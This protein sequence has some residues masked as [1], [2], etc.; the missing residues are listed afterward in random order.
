MKLN[1]VINAAGARISGGDPYGW[2]CFGDNANF[3]EFRD[4]SGQGYAHAIYDT[5]NYT[6]YEINVTVPNRD[7]CFRW[8]NPEFKDAFYS[9]AESRGVDPEEAW[10]DVK[11]TNVDSE[12]RI[13]DHLENIGECDYSEVPDEKGR[14][15]VPLEL[16][17]EETFR[18]MKAAHEKDVTLNQLVEDILRE[19][20]L[21]RKADAAFT[22]PMPGTLG[23]ATLVF[24]E[25]NEKEV[26]E[27]S[28]NVHLDV[29]YHL[30]VTAETAN[31]ALEKAKFFQETMPT[32]WGQNKEEVCWVDTYLVKESVEQALNI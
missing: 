26:E 19:E 28:F 5:K 12:A 22:M 14:V 13:I 16:T 30:E 2:G 24:P 29:R 32:G 3:I 23:S 9:D 20:I 25:E 21:L 11:C 31:D 10:D 18:L 7:I 6:V 15:S 8:L 17:E 27:K 4:T 1:D